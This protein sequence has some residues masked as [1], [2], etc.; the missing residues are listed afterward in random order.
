M[1]GEGTSGQLRSSPGLGIASGHDD[2]IVDYA[3]CITIPEN[4]GLGE[5][6][7][8]WSEMQNLDYGIG[9][10]KSVI[11]F[12]D[13]LHEQADTTALHQSV[14]RTY[15]EVS[16]QHTPPYGIS[17]PPVPSMCSLRSLVLKPERG[18]GQQKIVKL[19]LHTLQSYPLMIMGHDILPPFIHPASMAFG[20]DSDIEPLANCL[21]LMHMLGGGIRGSRKLFWRNVR[22]ECERMR[23]QQ[24]DMNERQLLAAM[25]ALSLY[26]LKRLQE[27]ETEHNNCDSLML[28]T[29][30][31]I[32][33]GFARA[34]SG[35]DVETVISEPCLETSWRAWILLE[36]RRRLAAIYRVVDMLVYFEPSGMCEL[37]ND[38]IIAPLP[39]EKYIWEAD[40]K[41]I[42]HD[43]LK[44]KSGL[45][46][47][48]ALTAGGEIVQLKEGQSY[49]NGKLQYGTLG[50]TAAAPVTWENWCSGMDG[51]GSLIMLAASLLP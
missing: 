50:D 42:W 23:E 11:D 16:T 51:F 27:G 13:F 15:L 5:Q 28:A 34:G 36:S 39:A 35:C 30:M 22:S 3:P 4:P 26:I 47:S 24:A 31:I 21:S 44:G 2:T 20:D 48:F 25:Q 33:G 8:G 12:A 49:C 38:L 14:P 18:P 9:W 17:I 29:F 43:G 1:Y 10:D 7:L 37:Q 40:N 6:H 19:V 45:R 32:A 41:H 46:E